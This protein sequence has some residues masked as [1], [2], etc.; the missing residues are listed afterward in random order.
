M[1]STIKQHIPGSQ[2]VNVNGWQRS[3]RDHVVAESKGARDAGSWLWVLP[4]PF[5]ASAAFSMPVP[6]LFSGANDG[7]CFKGCSVNKNWGPSRAKGD[8]G[9]L[10]LWLGG[11][12]RGYL[13]FPGPE[14]PEQKSLR[15]RPAVLNP[16][17]QMCH[18]YNSSPR[19]LRRS[20]RRK[21]SLLQ[22]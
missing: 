16:A 2:Q 1:A 22:Q 3:S 17:A 12:G 4:L 6:Y 11:M 15:P 10:G 20:C 19:F 21:M 18:W 9:S 7:M 13:S 5:L 14:M 8:S